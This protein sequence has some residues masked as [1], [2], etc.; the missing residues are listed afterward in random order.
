M[1]D[2]TY[3]LSL[4]PENAAKIDQINRIILGEA[5]TTEAANIKTPAKSEPVKAKA[6][7]A[8][9]ADDQ[10]SNAIAAA[11]ADEDKATLAQVKTAA[12]AAKKDH[13][14]DFV[15]DVLV[16]CGVDAGLTLGK[17]V[18]ALADDQYAVAI[19]GWEAG[20]Q[21]TEAASGELSDD[22]DFDD[23]DE[24][25]SE[26]TAEAVKVALKAYAKETGRDEAKAIM[27]KHGAA[28]L[29]KVDACTPK[30]LSAMFAELS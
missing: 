1:A 22:D 4:T 13:G 10:K 24:D 8:V 2:V 21:A 17:M 11:E 5:Y 12:K 6:D 28:A 20:P 16:G 25:T 19:T 3:T 23:E 7:A 15:K 14:E 26:V 27:V 18:G 30:Q 29:S 9:K